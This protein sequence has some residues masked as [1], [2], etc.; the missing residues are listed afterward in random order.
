MSGGIRN[1]TGFD[2]AYEQ[3][4]RPDLRLDTEKL[5]PEECVELVVRSLE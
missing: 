5:S 1:F 3:P 2:S 4:D